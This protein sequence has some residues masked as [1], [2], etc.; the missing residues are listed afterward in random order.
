MKR[1]ILL[2]SVLL[3]ITLFFQSCSQKEFN[4]SITCKELSTSL[5]REI[6]VPEGNFEEYTEDEL[7]FLFSTPKMYDDVCIVYSSDSTDV[8]EL[9]VLH[10]SSEEN[11]QLLYEEA[12]NYIK[13]TQEQKREFLRSYSPAELS[14][15]NC[16]EARLLGEYIVF[17]IAEQG[18]RDEALK[19]AEMLLSK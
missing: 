3:A 17:V 9:G 1:L 6:S 10:A 12:K 2:M 14:K 5:K 18:D 16:A 15:L 11:A 19:K 7:D 13:S 8:C 4:A